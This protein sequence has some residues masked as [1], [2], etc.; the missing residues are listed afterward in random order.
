MKGHLGRRT[1]AKKKRKA[2]GSAD[3]GRRNAN[4][5]W[6]TDYST[7]NKRKKYVESECRSV[8]EAVEQVTSG[9]ESY[10]E[11][12]YG[13]RRQKAILNYLD[14][15]EKEFG[16]LGL[17]LIIEAFTKNELLPL[18]NYND[19]DN[20]CDLRIGAALWILEK[21]R[22]AGKMLEAYKILPDTG[23]GTIEGVD[24]WY[25][26]PDFEHPCYSNDLIQSVVYLISSRYPSLRRRGKTGSVLTEENA[27]G[28]E[29]GGAY[30]EL[31]NLLPKDEVENACSRFRDKIW[32]MSS[33][34]MKGYAYYDREIKEATRQIQN[35]SLPQRGP[36]AM[37]VTFRGA[38]GSAE[39][40]PGLEGG[41]DVGQAM[42]LALRGENLIE[43]SHDYAVDFD[44]YLRMDCRAVRRES[45]QEVADAVSGFSVIDPYE[46]CFAL[47]YLI[48]HND[49][50]PWLIRS[51]SSLMLF[52]MR[53]LPWYIDQSDWN[54]DDWDA[55]YD[56]LQYGR[57][58]WLE[59][60]SVPEHLDYYHTM[61]GDRNLAQ[62]VYDLCRCV[63]PT[64]LH[65]F[66][67]DR[68]RLME[69]GMDEATARKIADTAELLF[70]SAFKAS[71]PVDNFLDMVSHEEKQDEDYNNNP[72]VESNNLAAPVKLGGYWGRAAGVYMPAAPAA[73]PDLAAENDSLK[74]QL[75]SLKNTLAVMWQEMSNERAKYERELRAL[76]LEHRELADLRELVFNA[77]ADLNIQTRREKTTK[78]YTYPY[79]TRQRTVVF[80]GHETWLKSIKPML[81]TVRFVNIENYA[82]NPDIVRNAD[83]V[84]I[85]NN[86]ISHTQ[87]G[88][89]V[90]LTRQYG[91]QLRYFTYSSAEK[92]AEQL[93]DEDL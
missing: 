41:F 30:K 8:L 7:P 59:K 70:L 43:K 86:C 83:V 35:F 84:W 6:E 92:C 67:E 36:L 54:D 85:Q 24:V 25:L 68:L 47:F 26:P 56:G 3:M 82:F 15:A 44:R 80:G 19:L 10:L 57:N 91:I 71:Q 33:R 11:G 50:S 5:Q 18:R 77:E 65:P 64:G 2:A 93:V 61:H 90:K 69:E 40:F 42:E 79:E 48:D 32:E 22:K 73:E 63:V 60:E 9:V 78:N 46:M 53:M 37:P 31:M 62:V 38:M 34:Y 88:N 14:R 75:K 27:G 76:R 87:Y 28:K 55:F 23:S 58:G 4:V 12:S 16:S 66:E 45:C 17:T 74:K 20:N 21:L 51:G 52:V 29:A 81:P 89:I 49:D 1:M 13:T 39:G 72:A